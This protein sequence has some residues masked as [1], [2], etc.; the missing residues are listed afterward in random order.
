MDSFFKLLTVRY[1]QSGGCHLKPAQT[2][3]EQP[4]SARPVTNVTSA[5]RLS[6]ASTTVPGYQPSKHMKEGRLGSIAQQQEAEGD[7]DG[8]SE[9]MRESER[10]WERER[11]REREKN[12]EMGQARSGRE[13]GADEMQQTSNLARVSREYAIRARTSAW[14]SSKVGAHTASQAQPV[15]RLG[16]VQGGVKAALGTHAEGRVGDD[17][18][19]AA[20]RKGMAKADSRS[21]AIVKKK[22]WTREDENMAAESMLTNVNTF[23]TCAKGI[24]VGSQ[25]HH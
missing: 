1:R 10:G 25:S 22:E 24:K 7:G 9:L 4:V 8:E 15:E 16:E 11:E 14:E 5:S 19:I 12:R 18:T 17:E 13:A 21:P 23:K 2:R 20:S 6:T 3:A